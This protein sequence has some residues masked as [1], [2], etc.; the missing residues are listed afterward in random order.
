M[1][2]IVHIVKYN[3]YTLC[4]DIDVFKEN[5]LLNN[6]TGVGLWILPSYFNHSCIDKNVG[7]FFIGDLM[8]VRTLRLISKGEELIASYTAAGSSYERRSRYLKSIDI[9]CQCRLCKLDISESEKT[10]L[11]RAQLLETYEKS[12]K[13]RILQDATLT[14]TKALEKIIT[15]L[16]SLRKGKSGVRI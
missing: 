2:R 4:Y 7:R 16:S 3:S 13:P 9:D 6:Y 8:F 11:R 1:E 14:L 10:K 15:E 5:S 12:I